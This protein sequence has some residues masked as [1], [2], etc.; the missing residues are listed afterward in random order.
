VCAVGG[1]LTYLQKLRAGEVGSGG[2]GG[3][4]IE[5]DGIESLSL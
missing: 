1:L 3:V 4:G 5:L 2:G